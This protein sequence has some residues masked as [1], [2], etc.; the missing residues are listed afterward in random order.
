MGIVAAWSIWLGSWTRLVWWTEETFENPADQCLRHT[1]ADRRR[2]VVLGRWALF[3]GIFCTSHRLYT[4]RHLAELVEVRLLLSLV[5]ILVLLEYVTTTHTALP[6]LG[7]ARALRRSLNG[8]SILL[9]ACG[10]GAL[11]IHSSN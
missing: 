11:L 9:A 6:C 8:I 4:A 2:V 10:V 7:H 5:P 1:G 3:V